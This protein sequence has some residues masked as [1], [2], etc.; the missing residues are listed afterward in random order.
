MCACNVFTVAGHG[1]TLYHALYCVCEIV[2]SQSAF[3]G[4]R[5]ISQ[6]HNDRRRCRL[7]AHSGAAR[8]REP[9]RLVSRVPTRSSV[10]RECFQSSRNDSIVRRP[11]VDRS[12]ATLHAHD[13]VGDRR[14]GTYSYNHMHDARGI[15]SSHVCELTRR[16]AILKLLFYFTQRGRGR[17]SFWIHTLSPP[18]E[19]LILNS[20]IHPWIHPKG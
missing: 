11:A 12:G 17:Y 5:S 2:E 4:N 6:W 10:N 3:V 16:T 9:R 18:P 15:A 1:V 14:Y 20:V 19:D 13:G 7:S 8:P